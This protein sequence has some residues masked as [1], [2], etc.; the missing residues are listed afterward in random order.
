MVFVFAFQWFSVLWPLW[1]RLF[2]SLCTAGPPLLPRAAPPDM[3]AHW[4]G[5]Q[6]EGSGREAA[7]LGGSGVLEKSRGV[8]CFFFLGGVEWGMNRNEVSFASHPFS[9]GCRDALQ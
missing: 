2:S 9:S 4:P 3:E 6:E 5:A 8:S 7:A 1:Q